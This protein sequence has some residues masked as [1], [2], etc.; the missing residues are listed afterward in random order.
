[1]KW[2]RDSSRP[3]GSEAS[4]SSLPGGVEEGAMEYS[5]EELAEFLE[6]D[7]ADVPTDLEFKQTLREKMWDLVDTRNRARGRWPSGA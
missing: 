5:L 7:L 3:N 1:M 6:A 2:L 4:I